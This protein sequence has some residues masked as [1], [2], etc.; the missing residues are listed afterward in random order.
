M[1]SGRATDPKRVVHMYHAHLSVVQGTALAICK[2]Y[3][4]YKQ[5]SCRSQAQ[6]ERANELDSSDSLAL[7]KSNY[8]GVQVC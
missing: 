3:R 4:T 8:K 6:Q 1:C 2:L 7:E 5:I